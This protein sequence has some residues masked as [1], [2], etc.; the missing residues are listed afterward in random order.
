M[1]E[2]VERPP[3][4]DNG[5]GEGGRQGVCLRENTVYIS[6]SQKLNLMLQSEGE[7]AWPYKELLSPPAR[8]TAA[9]QKASQRQQRESSHTGIQ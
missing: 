5:R 9:N 2:G 8:G 1:C 4:S 7:P 3:H 6:V